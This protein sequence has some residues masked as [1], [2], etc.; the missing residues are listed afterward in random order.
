MC[1]VCSGTVLYCIVCEISGTVRCA[2]KVIILLWLMY[3]FAPKSGTTKI[4][5]VAAWLNKLELWVQLL[6]CI[7]NF[8]R[9]YWFIFRFLLLWESKLHCNIWNAQ[10]TYPAL[11]QSELN[12]PVS[13]L[14]WVLLEYID[15]HVSCLDQNFKVTVVQS[16]SAHK[17]P[18]LKVKV[19]CYKVILY[20]ELLSFHQYWNMIPH[21]A[22]NSLVL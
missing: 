18:N 6:I 1:V 4:W 13:I 20:L 16:H 3:K 21:K 17:F 9:M 5:T 8:H 15:R 19:P 14:F 10:Y 22:S 2:W 12:W 11:Y 7:Y